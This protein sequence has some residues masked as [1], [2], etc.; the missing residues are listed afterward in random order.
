MIRIILFGIL[1]WLLFAPSI[2]IKRYKFVFTSKRAQ[3]G[4][5]EVDVAILLDLMAA[6]LSAGLSIPNALASLDYALGRQNNT[7]LNVKQNA[8]SARSLGEVSKMLLLGANWQE[9]WKDTPERWDF[10]QK[11]LAPAWCE[12]AAPIPLLQR[13]AHMLRLTRARRAKEA[14][15]KLSAAIVVPLATCFLP[16]FICIGVVPVIVATAGK[17]FS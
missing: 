8:P 1:I 16:A 2:R 6:A 5:E 17:I 7:S 14:A 13:S 10:L 3:A 9:A 12:G 11:A 4:A 15:A